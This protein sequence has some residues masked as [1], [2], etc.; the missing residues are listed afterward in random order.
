MSLQSQL[1]SFVTRVAEMFQQVESRTG[2]L[3]QLNTSAK[4]DLVTAINELAARGNGGSTTGGVAYTH[5][6]SLPNTVWTINHNLG[7]RPA[8]TILDTGGNEVEADVVHTSFN[9]LVI[10]FAVPIAG[11]AR[12]T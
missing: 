7:M 6:Q 1:N 5:L 4:S 11:I 2:P 12:L 3:H 9:Q 8:V 10:R